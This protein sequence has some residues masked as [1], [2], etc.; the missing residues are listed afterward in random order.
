MS[1]HLKYF[2]SSFG[3]TLLALPAIVFIFIFSYVP[4]Y[5]LVLPFKEYNF[6]KGF[7][8]SPW[9]GLTNFEF[10]FNSDLLHIIRNT[11]VMNALFIS[12]NV[13]VEV[14]VALLLFEL[15]KRATKVYQTVLFLPF[16]IS[17]IVVSYAVFGFL[18]SDTGIV[19]KLLAA[20][21]MDPVMFY[22]SPGYW[23]L[24]LVV[25]HV[26]KFLG[27][28]T[29]MYYAALMGIDAEYYEAARLD[30]ATRF[31]QAW[32]ISIPLIRPIIIIM[33]VL[34]IGNIFYSDFGLFYSVTQDNALLYPTTDVI[35]TYVY[36][37]LRQLGDFGMSSAAGL[38][39]SICG[40]IVVVLSNYA[41]GKI[42]KEDKLF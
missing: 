39:Q 38:F 42:S 37:A 17:W 8:H 22:N 28:G 10:L 14:A 7:L 31:Q 29:L 11:V 19:N 3:L 4:L 18:D 2:R 24:I 36:R 26:W 6:E 1:K 25:A 27:Y 30:G 34:S 41:I 40:F 23:P 13:I 15:G 20:F 21:G 5:G 16:F 35:D 12:I 33:V 9:I 32:H